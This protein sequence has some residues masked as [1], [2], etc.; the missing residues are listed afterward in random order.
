LKRP[1][2]RYNSLLES[3]SLLKTHQTLFVSQPDLMDKELLLNSLNTQTLFL[4]PIK[5][6]HLVL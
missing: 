2:K 6:G 1:G 5:D 3:L 4:H